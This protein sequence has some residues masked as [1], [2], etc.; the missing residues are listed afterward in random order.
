MQEQP[1]PPLPGPTCGY[2]VRPRRRLGF[3]RLF[4]RAPAQNPPAD[5][6]PG[7]S[8]APPRNEAEWTANDGRETSSCMHPE[9]PLVAEQDCEYQSDYSLSGG[10][11]CS[12]SGR[13]DEISGH[14]WPCIRPQPEEAKAADQACL[15]PEF[16]K[17]RPK[18]L[19]RLLRWLGQAAGALG[20]RISPQG[21]DCAAFVMRRGCGSKSDSLSGPGSNDTSLSERLVNVLTCCPFFVAGRSFSR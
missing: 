10:S 5:R 1:C 11:G 14:F 9:P 15:R 6:P 7:S 2:I 16:P 18:R 20:R 8:H 4:G 3:R 13:S 17:R 12:I 21:M 19:K